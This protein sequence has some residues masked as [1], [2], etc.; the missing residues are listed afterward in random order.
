VSADHVFLDRATGAHVLR[1]LRLGSDLHPEDGATLIVNAAL[2]TGQNLHMTGPGIDGRI[3][4][5]VSD[6]PDGFWQIRAKVMRD[7]IGFEIFLTDGAGVL[8][9]P[10]S[11]RVEVL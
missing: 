5:R 4:V 7:P 3:D 1:G 8:G 9:V 10:R 11:T 6:L 2:G